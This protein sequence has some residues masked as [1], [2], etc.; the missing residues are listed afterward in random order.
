MKTNDLFLSLYLKEKLHP[1]V[2]REKITGFYI[3]FNE[4]STTIND[5]Q[6]AHIKRLNPRTITI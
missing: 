5:N 6:I 3:K 1:D 2:N 4:L